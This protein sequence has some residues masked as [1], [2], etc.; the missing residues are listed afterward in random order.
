ML[1]E[2]IEDYKISFVHIHHMIGNFFNIMKVCE[3]KN[4]KY[5][6]SLHDMYLNTPIVSMID[7]KVD[8]NK[9]YPVDIEVWRETC[10]E[11]LNKAEI[12]NLINHIY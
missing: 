8:E 7:D 6:V 2:V 10:G 3:E 11:L 12:V 4:I 1:K 5:A 9:K